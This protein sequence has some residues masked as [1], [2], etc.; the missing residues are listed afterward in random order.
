MLI[1]AESRGDY[2][3][4]V[5]ERVAEGGPQ[6]RAGLLGRALREGPEPAWIA[7]L[8]TVSTVATVPQLQLLTV[9]TI[10]NCGNCATI[11]AV[12]NNYN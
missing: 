10:V 11:T 2:G 12:I 5:P 8:G 1:Y 6:E 7:T 3:P 4:E 9:T